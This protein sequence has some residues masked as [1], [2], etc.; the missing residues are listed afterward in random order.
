MTKIDKL[1]QKKNN[2]ERVYEHIKKIRQ[3]WNNV[4]IIENAKDQ[5]LQKLSKEHNNFADALEDIYNNTFK[6]YDEAW[7]E[8]QEYQE[9]LTK[10]K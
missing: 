4:K 8:Y 9:L 3:I 1:E 2:A 5:Q 6:A 7:G 10:N